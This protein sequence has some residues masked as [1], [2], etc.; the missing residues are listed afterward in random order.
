MINFKLYLENFNA[1]FEI[2]QSYNSLI[3]KYTS[4]SYI[5]Q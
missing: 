4:Q 3:P 1:E 2:E 5:F